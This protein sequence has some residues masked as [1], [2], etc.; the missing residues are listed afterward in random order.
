[1]TLTRL[2]LGM[3]ALGRPGYVTIGHAND[4]ASG[5]GRDAMRLQAHAVLDAALARGV[6]YVDAARSYGDAE[7][8]V[9]SWLDARGL[10]PGR[11]V[12]GSKWGYV[13]EAGWRVEAE[14]H[15]RKEHSLA[16]LRRQ[17]AESRAILGEHLALYQIHSATPES[18]VLEDAA[19]LDELARLRATG[20]GIGVTTSG[21]SQPRVVRRALEIERDGRPLFSSIQATWN[22]LERS[23]EDALREAHDAGRTVLVK[24][25]LANG[26]LTARGDE[27][28]RGAVGAL[29]SARGVT[30]DV[31][32]LAAALAQPWADV[33][34]LGASTVAQLE[35]NVR[36]RELT[37][38]P[39]ELARLD[40]LRVPAEVYWRDR[41][42]LP[43]N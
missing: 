10:A 35:S 41:A 14:S 42:R 33:V 43:W 1:M 19:I 31:V 39:P 8:F 18:G 24:E 28:A 9:R 4:F 38:A 12:V 6:H 15:E 32:A 22:L 13:Y 16:L 20:L 40:S 30:P 5:R 29:A 27:G 21:P 25:A 37:L 3:A 2:G 17:V 23:S 36:A 34:L 11:V 7:A 26:R